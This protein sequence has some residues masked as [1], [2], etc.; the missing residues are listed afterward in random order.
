MLPFSL[1]NQ[2]TGV[3]PLLNPNEHFD[4]KNIIYLQTSQ[5]K[6]LN[7]SMAPVHIDGDPCDTT[8]EFIITNKPRA[9]KLIHPV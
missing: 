9:F 2:V 1:L 3:N 7:P 6:I 4:K 8:E 5:V